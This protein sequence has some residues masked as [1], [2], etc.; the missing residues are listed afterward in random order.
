V[1]TLNNRELTAI[2]VLA[3]TVSQAADPRAEYEKAT[4][5]PAP[6]GFDVAAFDNLADFRKIT[7]YA[8]LAFNQPHDTAR[9]ALQWVDAASR[10]LNPLLRGMMPPL[11]RA[12]EMRAEI[13]AEREKLLRALR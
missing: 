5:S 8:A 6:A 1:L 2:T 4:G 12:K 3:R 11:Q 9:K 7:P 10:S 13:K